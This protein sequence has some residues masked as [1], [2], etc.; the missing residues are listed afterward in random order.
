MDRGTGA[1]LYKEQLTPHLRVRAGRLW[2][3]AEAFE[4]ACILH[5]GPLT[6]SNRRQAA[7]ASFALVGVES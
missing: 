3:C 7:P 4:V 1:R 6:I 5:K 2:D